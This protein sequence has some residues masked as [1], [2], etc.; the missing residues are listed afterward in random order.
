MIET[1]DGKLTLNLNPFAFKVARDSRA[2]TDQS[3]FE[4]SETLREFSGTLSFGGKGEK[5]DRDGDGKADD[6]LEAKSLDDIVQWEV[7]FQPKNRDMRESYNWERYLQSTR[8][9]FEDWA[10]AL[11]RLVTELEELGLEEILQED[12]QFCVN[13]IG[14]RNLLARN[15]VWQ[16]ITEEV[17][18]LAREEKDLD[19]SHDE[20]TKKIVNDFIWSV[21]LGGIE[22]GDDFGRD[23]RYAAFRGDRGIG[24]GKKLTFEAK[25]TEVESR[26]AGEPDP[27]VLKLGLEW[28]TLLLRGSDGLAEGSREK[29]SGIEL[30]WAGSWE[31]FN[32]VPDAKHDT[33]GKLG[34]KLELPLAGAMKL[35]ISVT[36]A[37]HVDL[38]TDEDEVVGH[39][40]ISWDLSK[41]MSVM[42]Q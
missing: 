10:T 25:W 1:G 41:V 33:I 16:V 35:P 39:I 8:D 6:P 20:I 5:F 27:E 37:N 19:A 40:G 38:L 21:A 36:W 14:L 28:S 4:A 7:R 32:D 22:R 2:W 11:E 29:T 18:T 42:P 31:Q 15:A 26:T 3:L 24:A 13:K 34:V 17:Q 9:Q 12:R 30:S 23:E